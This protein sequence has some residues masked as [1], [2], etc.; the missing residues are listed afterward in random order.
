MCLCINNSQDSTVNWMINA[1]SQKLA[2]PTV[3]CITLSFHYPLAAAAAV[4]AVRCGNNEMLLTH[5]RTLAAQPSP[6]AM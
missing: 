6:A 3:F 1:L 2:Y 5:R 4:A